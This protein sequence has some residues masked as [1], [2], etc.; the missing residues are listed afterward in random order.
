M[1]LIKIPIRWRRY[2]AEQGG[3]G[4]SVSMNSLGFIKRILTFI[5]EQKI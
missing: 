3:V 1:L 4:V 2:A 5:N